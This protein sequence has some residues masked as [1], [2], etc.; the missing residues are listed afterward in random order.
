MHLPDKTT[1][2]GFIG[3]GNMSLAIVG[4]L[5]RAG[6]AAGAICVAD[7]DERKHDPFHGLSIGVRTTTDNAQAVAGAEALVL[8]VKPQVMPHVL[9]GLD[10]DLANPDCVIISVAAGIELETF[11]SAMGR[12]ACIR[13][14]P[15]QGALTGEG[16]TAMVANDASTDAQ[17]ALA[18]AILGATG[19][20]VWI[21]SESLMDV[22]TAVSGSGPAYFY[23]L[24]EALVRSATQRGLSPETARALVSA[25]A[26]GAASLARGLETPLATLRERVTS[27]GGTTAAALAALAE[28]AF[29]ET[30]DAAI[31]AAQHRSRELA[32]QK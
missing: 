17:R 20:A 29:D 30:I 28:H 25:T 11:E 18:E 21:E 32:Q 22:V 26:G 10:L 3:G 19:T 9:A 2:V 13:S 6:W 24:M 14:M 31:S 12:R 7:P 27:P 8:A 15:N 23:A 5:L 4:G 1:R 16:A